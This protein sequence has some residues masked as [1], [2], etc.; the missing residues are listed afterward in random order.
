MPLNYTNLEKRLIENDQKLSNLF[1]GVKLNESLL[2]HI[3]DIKNYYNISYTKAKESKT[4]EAIIKDYEN[5]V[6]HLKILKSNSGVTNVSYERRLEAYNKATDSIRHARNSKKLAIIKYDLAQACK[7]TFWAAS[8]I[9]LY[10]SIFL[11]ALP[12]VIFQPVIGLSMSIS[13]GGLLLMTALKCTQCIREFKTL[14]RH[15]IEYRDEIELFGLFK[16][17]PKPESGSSVTDKNL[18]ECIQ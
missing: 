7:L 12:M 17:E 2:K 8:A 10:A 15:D 3:A 13:I 5:F 1:T 18:N 14:G 11:I 9:S 16:P 6:D 4:I